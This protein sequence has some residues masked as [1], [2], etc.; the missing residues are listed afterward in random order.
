MAHD[1]AHINWLLAARERCTF[2]KKDEKENETNSRKQTPP[3]PL[4][5]IDTTNCIASSLIQNN[6]EKQNYGIVGMFS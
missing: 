1:L 6:T 3:C 4:K 5:K 2:I